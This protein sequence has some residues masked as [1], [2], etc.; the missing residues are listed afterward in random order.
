M[1]QFLASYLRLIFSRKGNIVLTVLICSIDESSH[2]GV[3]HLLTGN[4]GF[5]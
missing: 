3:F 5:A 2:A 4:R 1:V